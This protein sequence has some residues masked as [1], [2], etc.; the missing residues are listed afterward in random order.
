MI[1]D[2]RF[3]LR[4]LLKNPSFTIVAILTLALGI[5]VNTAIFSLVNALL[6]RPLPFR[7]ANRLVWVANI[8]EP[9]LSGGPIRR[10][11]LRD[12]RKFDRSFDG[13]AGYHAFFE[14]I[15]ATLTG[16]GEPSR[17]TSVVITG[18][19]LKV[20]GV[21][22]QLGRGFTEE[23]CQHDGPRAVLLT[24]SFWKRRFQADPG[25]VGRSIEINAA[26]CSVVGVLP[27]SF[28]FSSIFAP[29]SDA[30]DFFR[31]APDIT[32]SKDT[33]GNIM[34]VVGRLKT[35]V[36]LTRAQNEFD[37]LN[38]Q[39]QA[40]YP[41]R[42]DEYR[43][44]LLSLRSHISGRFGPALLL[45]ACAVGCVLLIACTNLSNL[46]LSRAAA[47]R[48]E[49]AV[50]TALGASRFRIVRQMLT[51]SI[52]L[53]G[54]GAA[55][56]LPLAFISTNAIAHSHAFSLPL[57]STVRVDGLALS[58]TLLVAVGTGLLLESRPRSSLPRWISG[59]LCKRPATAPA[60]I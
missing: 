26:Q 52:L 37:L 30:V 49:I 18:D 46:L 48:K 57:L 36:S 4:Q 38:K 33:A 55:I 41:Q 13:L 3:A 28:D 20:L 11:T 10:T 6:F 31:P 2:I 39:L 47:R 60:I 17:L 40:E 21:A 34:A 25:T 27:G 8:A 35:D 45:L 22:P 56:G 24:D 50:R 43:A 16:N 54:F 14:R 19:F 1:S 51:E 32:E 5:G 59:M 9:G 15:D 44:R 58:F 53:S 42:A 23:E 7:E 29:G 12:W